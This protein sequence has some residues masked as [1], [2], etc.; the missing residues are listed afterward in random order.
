MHFLEFDKMLQNITKFAV[1]AILLVQR[2][3]TFAMPVPLYFPCLAPCPFHHT[4]SPCSCPCPCVRA[5]YDCTIE[6]A[7]CNDNHVNS[8]N[9]IDRT[10]AGY[11]INS[12]A[13]FRAYYIEWKPSILDVVNWFR[14]LFGPMWASHSQ[15]NE[16]PPKTIHEFIIKF[17]FSAGS[18]L[19]YSHVVIMILRFIVWFTYCCA[20]KPRL[21]IICIEFYKIHSHAHIRTHT[22]IQYA[23]KYQILLF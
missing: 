4:P 5:C 20:T 21:M 6:H 13:F 9:F 10:W 15:S 12:Q 16:M 23:K 19:F 14:L 17:R 7:S 8:C 22:R 18:W 2:V 11:T 3:N 1:I